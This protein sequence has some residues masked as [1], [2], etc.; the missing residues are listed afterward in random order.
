MFQ[1]LQQKHEEQVS[2]VLLEQQCP[3]ILDFF[4]PNLSNQQHPLEKNKG[5]LALIQDS[6]H[7]ISHCSVEGKKT[8]LIFF[9]A[10]CENRLII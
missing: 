8:L 10:E 2:Q 4:I 1:L 6:P 7:Q 9:H 3:N 5:Q